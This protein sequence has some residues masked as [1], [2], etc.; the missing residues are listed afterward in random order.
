M[1]FIR[2][3]VTNNNKPVVYVILTYI[4]AQI[5]VDYNWEL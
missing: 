1:L 5:G 4:Y 3:L 2:I